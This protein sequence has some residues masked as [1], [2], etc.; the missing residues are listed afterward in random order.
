[1]AK[2][3]FKKR[4]KGVKNEKFWRFMFYEKSLLEILRSS[5]H[6]EVKFHD[7]KVHFI[8]KSIENQ[9]QRRQR[10]NPELPIC[11]MKTC[12]FAE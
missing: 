5:T 7:A 1:M 10:K 12:Q 9:S 6:H 3:N 11:R 4:P 8:R 2:N